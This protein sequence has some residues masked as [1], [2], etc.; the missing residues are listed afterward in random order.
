MDLKFFNRIVLGPIRNFSRSNS[1]FQRK[2][3]ITT[4]GIV[5]IGDEILKGEVL[6]SNSRFLAKE[7]H[8]LGLQLRK[9]SIIPDDVEMISNEVQSFSKK[10][11]FVLTTGGIGPTHDDVT[12]EGVAL[13]FDKPLYLH[14]ELKDICSEFYKTEDLSDAGMKLAYIPKSSILNYKTIAGS[15]LAYPMVSI[16]NVYMFPGIPELLQ[17]T[18]LEVGPILF[19][20]AN[21]FYN[22]CVFCNL[23]EHKIVTQLQQVVDQFPDVRFGCYPKLFNSVY[24]VKLTIESSNEDSTLKAHAR[25]MELIPKNCIVDMDDT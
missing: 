11:D 21:R 7:L 14:P 13:A 4:A 8:K 16:K 20:C 6:D 9:I 15:D 18:I 23:P 12:Y 1:R 2:P 19:Q 17:K 5:V 3:N 22:R 24:K 25:L 10:Y